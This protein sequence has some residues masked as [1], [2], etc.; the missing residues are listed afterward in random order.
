MNS[1]EVKTTIGQRTADVHNLITEKVN[2]ELYVSQ[3]LAKSVIKTTIR[4][5]KSFYIEINSRDS[6]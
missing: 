3:F 1:E 5:N 4:V 2:L 6:K